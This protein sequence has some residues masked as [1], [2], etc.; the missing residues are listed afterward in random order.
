MKA[1]RT[2]YF[3]RH[4][5]DI[6]L[7]L[8][9][10]LL[11]IPCATISWFSWVHY[12]ETLQ[13]LFERNISLKVQLILKRTDKT[14]FSA[15][16]LFQEIEAKRKKDN[17]GVLSYPK[18]LQEAGLDNKDPDMT[19]V[20][21][22]IFSHRIAM[23]TIATFFTLLSLILLYLI[24]VSYGNGNSS[25]RLNR[26]IFSFFNTD[27]AS[28]SPKVG[29]EKLSPLKRVVF[30]IGF[31]KALASEHGEFLFVAKEFFRVIHP[32]GDCEGSDMIELYE[33]FTSL[34]NE[35]QIGR[36]SCR[37]RVYTKV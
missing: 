1:K 16:T 24:I 29:I 26:W 21:L 8:I 10:V 33:V 37:E 31:R 15:T 25:W 5:S 17:E 11:L 35:I 18:Y 20:R 12:D 23:Y 32:K 34:V 14:G 27:F 19:A 4:V 9:L 2:Y 7:R 36:A 13:G 6:I 3:D 22:Y 30:D 28:I